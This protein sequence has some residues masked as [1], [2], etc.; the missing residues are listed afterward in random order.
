MARYTGVMGTSRGTLIRYSAAFLAGAALGGGVVDVLAARAM[1]AQ[2]IN[3]RARFY[4]EQTMLAARARCREEWLA[5]AFHS[6][7]AA[8]AG[9]TPEWHALAVREEDGSLVMPLVG[10]IL[11]PFGGTP[12]QQVGDRVVVGLDRADLARALDMLGRPEADVEWKRAARLLQ[13]T[14]ERARQMDLKAESCRDPNAMRGVEKVLRM[15][16]HESTEPA[17]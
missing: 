11:R 10:G 9:L 1:Q 16:G 6:W 5:V 17:N 15:F 4:A 8:S 14:E 3:V 7:N 2:V 12:A 13:T